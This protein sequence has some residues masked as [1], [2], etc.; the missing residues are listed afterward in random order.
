MRKGRKREEGFK[1]RLENKSLH[2]LTG[3]SLKGQGATEDSELI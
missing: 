3:D 1:G 2:T